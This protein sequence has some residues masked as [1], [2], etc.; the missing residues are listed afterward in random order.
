[1]QNER[2]QGM[3]SLHMVAPRTENRDLGSPQICRFVGRAEALRTSM[4]LERSRK[5]Q[6]VSEGAERFFESGV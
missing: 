2:R 4:S 5:T 6:S 3:P 1:M